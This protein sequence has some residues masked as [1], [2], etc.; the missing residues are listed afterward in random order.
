MAQKQH[1]TAPDPNQ[2]KFPR[3]VPFII[4][5][6]V[7]ERFS[8]YGMKAILM[9]FMTEHLL[10]AAGES[11]YMSDE[12][13]KTWYHA[14]TGLAYTFPILGAILADAFW[15]KYKTI[16][17]ISL[18]YCLGHGMLALMDLGPHFG[19]WD[20]KPFLAAGLILIAIG[21]GGIKPCVSAHVGDQFG[22][23]NKRLLTQIFNWFYF[24]INVGAA[25]SSFLTP[26]LLAEFGPWLAFGLPGALMAIATFVFWL[27][28]N[29]FVHVPAAGWE[30]F[31]AET[32][33]PAGI[34]ALKN[35]APLF[36]IFV[37]VF[38][39]IFDQ[40]GSAWVLQAES[41]N[42]DFMGI[43]WLKSQVQ[44]VNP[45]LILTGIPVFTYLVYPLMG[46]FFE[47]TPLRKIGIGFVM[48]AL[49][50]ALSAVIEIWIASQ[51]GPASVA[52]WAHIGQAGD[53]P[54]K[55]AEVVQVAR[56]SGMT[57]EQIQPFLADMPS[58]GWQF[59]AYFILTAGEIMVSIVCL[60][61]AYTQSPKKMKSFIMGVFFLGVALGNYLAMGVNLVL[62]FV[63]DDQGNTPLDGAN[64]YWFFSGLMIATT[65][66]Y[67]I[68]SKSYKGE[69]FIQGEEDT[70]T[71][72]T[73]AEAE[74]TEAR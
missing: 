43:T 54:S 46:R 66:I 18:M 72:H 33:S 19:L 56:D 45:I 38:W 25:A 55:L 68:W 29:S 12:R 44:L 35:L 8:F 70:Q 34:R 40:T 42:R 24:S 67:L 58:I 73:E 3:G 9:V 57:Q 71:L 59:L 1:L 37:A 60:E 53:M 23:G 5:N 31:K 2:T 52:L 20:M 17:L 63:K 22:K 7:A 49:A 10:N 69:E 26:V 47:P 13:A 14:F 4:G 64:Y 39:A 61:F 6:E 74:G 16:L 30:K 32:F 50:F 15:G 62:D 27:G 28:R 51:G 21:A 48:T 11:A 65:V 36:V 41:M